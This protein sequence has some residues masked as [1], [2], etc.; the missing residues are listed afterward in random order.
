MTDLWTEMA[1]VAQQH[2]KSVVMNFSTTWRG[3]MVAYLM[4]GILFSLCFG[5]LFNYLISSVIGT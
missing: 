2:L 3:K 1:G 4:D 5:E